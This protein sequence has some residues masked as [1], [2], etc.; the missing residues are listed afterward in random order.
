[1]ATK[2]HHKLEF[3]LAKQL[4]PGAGICSRLHGAHFILTLVIA[5]KSGDLNEQGM[6][7]DYMTLN[8]YLAPLLETLDHRDLGDIPPFDKIN[9]STEHLAA[10]CFTSIQDLLAPKGLVLEKIYLKENQGLTI[11]YHP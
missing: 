9:P 10:Y 2:I 5:R 1:M 3:C 6:V 4:H 8:E 7:V 11:E